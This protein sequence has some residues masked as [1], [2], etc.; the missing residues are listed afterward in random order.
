MIEGT[1]SVHFF[2]LLYKLELQSN[3]CQLG[4]ISKHLNSNTLID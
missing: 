3:Y 2:L 1:A 4:K